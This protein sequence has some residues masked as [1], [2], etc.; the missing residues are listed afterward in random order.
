MNNEQFNK[1]I[2]YNFNTGNRRPITN[3]NLVNEF[4]NTDVSL[5]YLIE[6][7]MYKTI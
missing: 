2:D 3:D 7:E 6:V 5:E 4:L 1:N